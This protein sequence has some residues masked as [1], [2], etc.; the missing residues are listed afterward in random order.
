MVCTTPTRNGISS[1]RIR[2]ARNTMLPV[3][4]AMTVSGRPASPSRIWAASLST[5]AW[6]CA[7]ETRIF[8][9]AFPARNLGV[10]IDCR[11]CSIWLLL[12]PDSEC[13]LS[14]RE[15][16]S[17]RGAKGDNA[18]LCLPM[19]WSTHTVAGHPVDVYLPP[20]RNEHGYVVIY[21]HG[22]HQNK[23]DD[24]QPFM[25]GFDRHGLAVVCPYTKR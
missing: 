6:I 1:L 5:E 18:D 8:T 10:V 12:T 9:A 25:E 19:P 11:E 13:R 16:P 3:M 17:F 15:R 2:S 14:H 7:A 20:R 4:M 22:L 23:L 24:K 21:L